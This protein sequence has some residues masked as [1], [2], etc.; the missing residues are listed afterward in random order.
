MIKK[1]LMV[2][3]ITF[4]IAFTPNQTKTLKVE[5]DLQ[6]WN[7]ILRVIDFSEAP[8]KERIA[9]RDFIIN[10]LNDTTKNKIKP[11]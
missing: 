5:A 4:L 9:V 3:A 10:Q 11:K 6:T 2:L 1:I 8:A 7:T